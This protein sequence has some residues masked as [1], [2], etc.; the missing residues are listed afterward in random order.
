MPPSP[1]LSAPDPNTQAFPVLTPVQIDRIRP[2]GL[3][4]GVQSGETLY[5]PND[6]GV[7]FFV[8]LS[9]Q[10]EVLRPTLD[11]ERRVVIH[12][13]GC[14]TDE[15]TMIAGQGCWVHGRVTA[16]GEFLELSRDAMLALVARDA[17][18]SEILIRF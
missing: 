11:G 18:L 8:V 6:S 10:M 16:P 12:N 9:G 14:F 7:P 3:I 5:Q 15:M 2:L 4:R 1:S 13:P 17:E